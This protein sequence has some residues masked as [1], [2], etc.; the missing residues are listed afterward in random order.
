VQIKIAHGRQ[1]VSE[2]YKGILATLFNTEEEEEGD[3]YL[4]MCPKGERDCKSER[5]FT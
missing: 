4:E 1:N 2:K 3:L 5:H